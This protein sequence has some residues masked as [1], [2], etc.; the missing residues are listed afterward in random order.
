MTIWPIILDSG[1]PC[2]GGRS[3][4]LVPLG[5]ETLFGQLRAW[6]R[7]ITPKAPLIVAREGSGD[8]DLAAL[9][10][11][12]VSAQVVFGRQELVD[13]IA[14]CELSDALLIV[15]PRCLPVDHGELADFVRHGSANPRVAH[16]LVALETDLSGTKEH[17]RVDANG[18]VRGVLRY[19]DQATWPFIA[20]VAAALVPVSCGVV[21][22]EAMPGSLS[23]L[24]QLLAARGVTSRDVAIANGAL[25]LS[26]EPG[27]LAAN[28][29]FVLEAMEGSLRDANGPP[30]LI[31]DGHSIHPSVRVIGPVVI[32]S[33]ARIDEG[34]TLIGPTLIGAGAH[35]AMGA[36]VAHATIGAHCAVP[37]GAVVRERTWFEDAGAGSPGLPGESQ[38][39][40]KDRLARLTVDVP[41]AHRHAGRRA[42]HDRAKRL[43]DVTAAVTGLS[44]LSPLLLLIAFLIWLESRGPVFY[45]QEREGLGGHVFK[46]WKFRTMSVDA[47][48]AQKELK[49][50]DTM[51]GPH[52]K[53]AFDPRV[54]RVGRV[55]RALNVDELPQLMNV[56]GGDMSLVGPRPSPFRENQVCVPWREARLSV[57]PGITG[58]WQ[59]CR[60]DRS[61]GDFHQWIEYDLLYVRHASIW[62]DLKILTATVLTLGGKRPVRSSW[63]VG[64]QPSEPV[65][66]RVASHSV[67][68]E[69]AAIV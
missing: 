58:L 18:H 5:T 41:T 9:R 34:V 7:S 49:S 6:L 26:R 20:G 47:H 59:V 12:C 44:I 43:L 36:I 15:D 2:R 63:L 16:Q 29:Q 3:A 50:L 4:L 32:H 46:C 31:G 23:E 45:G 53:L 19:Y 21:G 57:R 27:V 14:S 24:R 40:Y 30:L 69:E 62:L 28:E 38:L 56:A 60:H 8:D 51:D 48:S 22:D 17:V 35:V 61:S 64:R 55:L 65:G 10:T 67:P 39:S 33:Q 42:R 37:A 54:T 66:T 68:A 25:D 13:A 11:G 52:F 1:S